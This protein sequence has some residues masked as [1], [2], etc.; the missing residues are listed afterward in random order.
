ML[1]IFPRCFTSNTSA[2]ASASVSGYN[3]PNIQKSMISILAVESILTTYSQM[4]MQMQQNANVDF[5]F[6][7]HQDNGWKWWSK[8]PWKPHLQSIYIIYEDEDDENMM[9]F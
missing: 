2:S 4:K 7:C 8:N 6:A 1:D 9:H 3:L 5:A